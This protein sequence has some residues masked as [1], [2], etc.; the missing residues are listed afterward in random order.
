MPETN[1][2]PY[3][4]YSQVSK[5]KK[6]IILAPGCNIIKLLVAVNGLIGECTSVEGLLSLV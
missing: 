1:T 2:P 3:L 5:K 4:A 6:L